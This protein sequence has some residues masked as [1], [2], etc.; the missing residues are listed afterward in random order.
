MKDNFVFL[1]DSLTFGYGVNKNDCW[2]TL[3]QNKSNFN[4]LNKSVNG[5]TTTYMLVR[6]DKDVL[7]FNPKITFIMGGTNDLLCNR[8]LSYIISNIELMIKDLLLINSSV[9]IG[10]PPDIIVEDAYKLFMESPTYDYCKNLLPTLR[11]ELISLCNN[12]NCK[13]ID[14]YSLTKSNI[15]NNIYLDGIHLNSTGQQ[16]MLNEIFK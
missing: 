16:L 3:L 1:G 15:K 14:F 10:I 4:I 5:S 9:I 2:V 13:Y 11:E 8:C 12:Y 7:A 6:F